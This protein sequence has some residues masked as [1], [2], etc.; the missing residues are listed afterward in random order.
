MWPGFCP[1]GRSEWV[2][3]RRTDRRPGRTRPVIVE[4]PDGATVLKRQVA[5]PGESP[6]IID[7]DVLVGGTFLRRDVATIW[8][9]RIPLFSLNDL[10]WSG[11]ADEERRIVDRRREDPIV[12]VQGRVSLAEDG[13]FLLLEADEEGRGAIRV[14]AESFRDAHRSAEGEVVPGENERFEKLGH[15]CYLMYNDKE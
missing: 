5:G 9:Q 13:G 7:G 15:G 14:P 3:V 4:D 2:L 11:G 1:D 10:A 6:R 12:P 8:A